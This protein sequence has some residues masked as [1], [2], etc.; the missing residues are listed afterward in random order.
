LLQTTAM[1]VARIISL[2]SSALR[3][4]LRS[5]VLRSVL[6]GV[7]TKL[8][9]ALPHPVIPYQRRSMMRSVARVSAWVA[10]AA[11]LCYAPCALGQGTVGKRM[12]SAGVSRLS[13][14][15]ASF[16][17]LSVVPPIIDGHGGNFGNNGN[18]GNSC[19]NQGGPI[20]W[21]NGGWNGWGN[22]GGGGCSTSVPEGGST[23]MYLFLAGFCCAGALFFRSQRQDA[24]VASAN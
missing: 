4:T 18:G 5:V 24:S 9:S 15:P 16:L 13:H 14:A 2:D 20:G 22:G 6:I 10:F 1:G 12:P 11:I 19:G 21:E 17:V 8:R 3:A 7:H 23:W